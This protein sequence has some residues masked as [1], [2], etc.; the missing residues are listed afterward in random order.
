MLEHDVRAAARSSL[1][2]LW[3]RD[4][5]SLLAPSASARLRAWLRSRRLDAMLSEGADP[6]GS[7]L[8]AAR[9]AQLTTRRSRIRVALGLERLAL[10]ADTGQ[11]H[12]RVAPA[13]AAARANRA[14]L[15]AIA[16]LLREDR[17]LYARGIA[18]LRGL[19]ADGTGPAYVDRHGDGLAAALG[20]A[21]STLLRAA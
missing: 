8:L 17:C 18:T 9:A 5:S 15:L 21:R 13:R 19:L 16:G 6:A 1:S 3:S 7:A 4:V 14:E 20:Q 2:E 10:C 11:G 12:W